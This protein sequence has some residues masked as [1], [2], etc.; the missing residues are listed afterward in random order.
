M[1]PLPEGFPTKER[2]EAIEY[3]FSTDPIY[4]GIF[5]RE[6]KPTLEER[7]VSIEKQA[8]KTRSLDSLHMTP[9][10]VMESYL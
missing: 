3:S 8:R 9:K 4:T 5:F 7:F 2:I 1:T 10:Q 6:S